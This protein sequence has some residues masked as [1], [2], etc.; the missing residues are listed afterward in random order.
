MAIEICAPNSFKK[1]LPNRYIKIFVGGSIEMGKATNW[2]QRL[3]EDFK[4]DNNVVI[5][6]P[7]RK[8]WNPN[9]K[10][11]KNNP[12]FKR[13]VNW[14]LDALEAANAIIMYFEPGTKSPIS[15]LELGLFGQDFGRLDLKMHVVCPS[16]FWRKGNVDIVCD[17]YHIPQFKTLN[18]AIMEIKLNL[19]RYQEED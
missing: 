15:L 6:N 14:E 4:D 16:G 11:T 1:Y 13:Q 7:R 3:L 5:L 19:N 9:W 12:P 8:K 18:D 17:R 10:Q 2:Q